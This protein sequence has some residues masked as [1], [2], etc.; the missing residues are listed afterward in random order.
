[1][2]PIILP[3]GLAWGIRN[4]WDGRVTYHVRRIGTYY[5]LCGH[6]LDPEGPGWPVPARVCQ[7]CQTIA[8][9]ILAAYEGG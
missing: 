7:R 6:S 9:G 4:T 3:E 8:S 1:M 5:G 2:E